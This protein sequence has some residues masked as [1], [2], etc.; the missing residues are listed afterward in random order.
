MRN[1]FTKVKHFIKHLIFN[2]GSVAVPGNLID[3]LCQIGMR[4][5]QP[6]RNGPGVFAEAVK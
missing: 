5:R 4:R 6:M 1:R 2:N 3:A